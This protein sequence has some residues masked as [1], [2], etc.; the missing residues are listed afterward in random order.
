[1]RTT[2]L[3]GA[4]LSE[5]ADI[6]ASCGSEILLEQL[7]PDQTDVINTMAEAAILIDAVGKPSISGMFDFHNSI[8][9]AES[10]ETLVRAYYP[11]IH[12]VHAN[13]VDGR[14]P[15]TGNSD[16]LPAFKV[17][18]SRGYDRWVSIEIFEI[19]TD[20]AAMLKASMDLFLKLEAD[21]RQ[22]R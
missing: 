1:M 22:T 19:P 6:A 16:Y 18:M 9:E 2:E 15:G 7:S 14:A 13:E 17:L 4:S 21:A 8:S 11:Y 12:H 10:W 3:L 20:P 5:L